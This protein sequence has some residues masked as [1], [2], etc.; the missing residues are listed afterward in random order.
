[1]ALVNKIGEAA[2][3]ANYYLDVTLSDTDVIVALSSRDVHGITR[4]EVGLAQQ[5][6]GRAADLGVEADVR[7]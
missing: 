2:E 1:L 5:I 3:A 7:A 4:Q 6:S